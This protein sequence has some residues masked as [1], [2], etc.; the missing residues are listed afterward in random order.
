MILF[1]ANNA[2]YALKFFCYPFQYGCAPLHRAASIGN[3]EMCELL[4]EEGAIVD[5]T[6]KA[7]QTPLMNAVIC[8]NQQ[9]NCL[10]LNTNSPQ[11]SSSKKNYSFK[12]IIFYR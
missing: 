11:H 4:I 7:G 12:L 10:L 3:S 8:Q 6:D 5:I 1:S 9:V 2:I